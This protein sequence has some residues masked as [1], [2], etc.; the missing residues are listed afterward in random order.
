MKES[1]CVSLCVSGPAFL[2]VSLYV[3]ILLSVSLRVPVN[4]AI[5]PGVGRGGSG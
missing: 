3:C 5:T 2:Y 1:Q 4:V